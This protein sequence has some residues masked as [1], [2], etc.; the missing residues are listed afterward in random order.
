MVGLLLYLD[1]F[2]RDICNSG[3]AWLFLEDSKDGILLFLSI[4]LDSKV[5]VLLLTDLLLFCDYLTYKL[6]SGVKAFI[7]GY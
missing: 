3:E 7:Y 5:L 4:G 1:L 2:D 6:G